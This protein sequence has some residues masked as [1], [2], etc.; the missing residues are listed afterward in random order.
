[1]ES[2]WDALERYHFY[3][4]SG[5][6]RSLCVGDDGGFGKGIVMTDQ[7]AVFTE[8]NR[9][10][11]QALSRMRLM[12]PKLHLLL[13]HYYRGGLCEPAAGWI[14]AAAKAGFAVSTK[15]PYSRWAFDWTLE[16]AV[17]LLWSLHRMPARAWSMTYRALAPADHRGSPARW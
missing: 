5:R 8:A 9:A 11:D 14:E 15:E 2:L 1:M 3:H 10:I 4:E 16:Q 13:H 6:I 12:D 17:V 7:W